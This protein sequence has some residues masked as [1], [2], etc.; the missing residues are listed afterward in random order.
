MP[1][2]TFLKRTQV[3]TLNY[4][5]LSNPEQVTGNV[6]IDILKIER[7]VELNKEPLVL[8]V[9]VM[10]KDLQIFELF[11]FHQRQSHN[12]FLHRGVIFARH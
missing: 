6:L 7:F 1:T 10:I 2:S 3:L 5:H 4:W 11:F 8:D 12:L 9:K